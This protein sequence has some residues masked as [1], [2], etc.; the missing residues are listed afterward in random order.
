VLFSYDVHQSC[1]PVMY[2]RHVH[3]LCLAYVHFD[4]KNTY[5]RKWY[6]STNKHRRKYGIHLFYCVQ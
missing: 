2:T 3:L 4:I 5:V 1:T 6:T